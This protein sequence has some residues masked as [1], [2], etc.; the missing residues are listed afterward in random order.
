MLFLVYAILSTGFIL[1]VLKTIGVPISPTQCVVIIVG[2]VL[3]CVGVGPYVSAH[4]LF[5]HSKLR[6]PT[7]EEEKLIDSL[8][9]EVQQ[10][11]LFT[12]PVRLWISEESGLEAF[13]AGSR[14]IAISKGMLKIMTHD[15]IKG[16]MAHELGHLES[17]DCRIGAAYITAMK[18]TGLIWRPFTIVQSK[19]RKRFIL[20]FAVIGFLYFVYVYPASKTTHTLPLIIVFCF[21]LVFPLFRRLNDFCW[22]VVSRFR[23]YRQDAFAFSI[24]YGQNL[25]DALIKSTLDGD[26]PVNRYQNLMKGSHPI[27]YN[28][29]RRLEKLLGLRDQ[30]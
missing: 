14:T 6:M 22:F 3:Y 11:T 18:L 1:F 16:I 23:E 17:W 30:D 8:F 15:E 4:Y 28:R 9:L 21:I 29:I 20:L 7:L 12:N 13:A 2:W 26:M 24:G 19:I 25:L 27:I 10:R 5:R